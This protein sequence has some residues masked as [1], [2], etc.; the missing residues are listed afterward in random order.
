M[1]DFGSELLGLVGTVAPTI[2][3][4][5][6][7]P[8][9][10]MAVSAICSAIGLP[11]GAEPAEVK[12]ALAAPSMDQMLALKQADD[13]FQTQMRQLD[14]DLAKISQ[15]DT[16]NARARQIAMPQ[17]WTPT[18]LAGV[19]SLGFFG[20]VY[21]MVVRS[22][23][24]ENANAVNILLGTLGTGWVQSIAYYFGSSYGSKSK[25]ALLFQSTPV[26]AAP[27]QRRLPSPAATGA[28]HAAT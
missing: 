13:A 7:T 9:A 2:A 8:L 3:S 10:G 19:L 15:T 20:L 26:L 5:L 23:P 16:A 6:G 27:D 14:V 1:A 22:V 21:L 24:P 17:D 12:A 18:V 25:D 4:A 28:T 11:P